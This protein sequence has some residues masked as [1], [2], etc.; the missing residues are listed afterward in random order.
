MSLAMLVTWAPLNNISSP[1]IPKTGGQHAD[2]RAIL[3]LALF[4]G[5]VQGENLVNL[6][7]VAIVF[8]VDGL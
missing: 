5:Q 1:S 2:D 7:D 3:Y 6:S 4:K 8:Q